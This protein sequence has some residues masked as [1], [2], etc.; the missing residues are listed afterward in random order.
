MTVNININV[1]SASCPCEQSY[2][3]L[4]DLTWMFSSFFG[5]NVAAYKQFKLLVGVHICSGTQT[6]GVLAGFAGSSVN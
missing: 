6:A 1:R 5:T 2:M 4:Q 3:P